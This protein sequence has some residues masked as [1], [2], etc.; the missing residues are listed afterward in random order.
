[1][2]MIQA[3][4]YNFSTI[5]NPLSNG[6]VFTTI[7]DVNFTGVLKAIA[8]NLCEPTTTA[9]AA[10]SFY[11]GTVAAPS[12]T[13]PADQYTEMT[14]TTIGN[15]EFFYLVVRQGAFNSGTQYLATCGAGGGST[16]RT[17]GFLA[18]VAGVVH[19]F[20]TQINLT[21]LQGD[22]LRLTIVGNVLTVTR[23]G[24]FL[25]TATDTNN[26]IA[27]GSP[28]FGLLATPGIA[29]AQTALWAAGANQS[30]TPTFS[31][32]A[33]SYTGTQTVTITSTSGGTI[34]YTTD[35]STPTHSS[36]SI[37]SGQTIN[38]AVSETVKAIASAA[39]NLDSTV[40][41][42]SYTIIPVAKTAAASTLDTST[43]DISAS[44]GMNSGDLNPALLTSQTAIMR[45]N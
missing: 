6:G 20:S 34:Y 21:F 40:A 24:S 29:N 2:S 3:A 5:E 8:G 37:S 45:A 36:S 33:G 43:T 9:V 17:I 15:S 23:N 39:N 1:M 22:V 31:P 10:A 44:A 16:V 18:I 13:W 25:A 11:S 27:S 19:S 41:S 32:V 12:N 38:V 26:Y 28:G 30:A 14:L 4:S 42:T 35:G 7:A